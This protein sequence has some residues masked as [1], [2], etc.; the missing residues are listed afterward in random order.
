[1]PATT[2]K[3]EELLVNLGRKERS[4]TL[5]NLFLA[6]AKNSSDCGCPSVHNEHNPS[7]PRAIWQQAAHMAALMARD[8]ND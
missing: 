2:D 5:A 8:E 4:E 6:L 7:C 1:M 3:D